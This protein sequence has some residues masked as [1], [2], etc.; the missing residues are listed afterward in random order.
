MRDEAA[1]LENPWKISRNPSR[2]FPWLQAPAKLFDFGQSG[3]ASLL[4]SHGREGQGGSGQTPSCPSLR[5]SPLVL[6]R[7]DSN[8]PPPLASCPIIS[9]G[10]GGST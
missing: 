1:E 2:A 8:P 6:L 10:A 7:L 9:P 4:L 3:C 5:L